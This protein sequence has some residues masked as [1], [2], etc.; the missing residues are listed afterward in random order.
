MTAPIVTNLYREPI[1]PDMLAF[2]SAS[3]VPD[4]PYIRGVKPLWPREAARARESA[5]LNALRD[6]LR[7]AG[8]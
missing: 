1:D 3:G 8:A 5:A 7:E 2:M 6:A 4:R